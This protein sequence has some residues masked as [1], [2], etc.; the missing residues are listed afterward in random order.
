MPQRLYYIDLARQGLV[1]LIGTARD[2]LSVP[3]SEQTI[4]G[5]VDV[6]MGCCA[7]G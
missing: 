1:M 6:M 2:V 7:C 4:R 3:G 5:K